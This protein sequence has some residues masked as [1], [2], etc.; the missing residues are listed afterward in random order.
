M[1]RN[2]SYNKTPGELRQEYGATSN[3]WSR[4]MLPLRKKKIIRLHIKIYTPKELQAI[5][6]HLGSPPNPS[7]K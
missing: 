6:D 5:Y 4:W 3:T 2:N 1:Y 7:A